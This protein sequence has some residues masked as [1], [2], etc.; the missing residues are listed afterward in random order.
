MSQ[1]DKKRRDNVCLAQR[2]MMQ[3]L[4]EPYEW[5]EHDARAPKFTGVDR[6]TWEELAEQNLVRARCWDRY[7]LTGPG[8]IAGLRLMGKFEEPEFQRIA[9]ALS[10]ALKARVKAN[11]RQ[12]WGYA[13][14][15][16]LAQEMGVSEFFIYDAVDSHL[17]REMFGTID[18]TWAK[19]DGMK[20]SIEIPPRFGLNALRGE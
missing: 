12:Q 17:L 20:N 9:G 18:A 6:T 16:E 11:N 5:Q 19:D 2:L 15:T 8:W 10:A 13:D 1:S 14:R 3:D 4:G 7:Q